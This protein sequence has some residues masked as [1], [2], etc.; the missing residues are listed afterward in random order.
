MQPLARE[1]E[2]VDVL[3]PLQPV[4]AH[5][6]QAMQWLAAHGQG[7]S[8]AELIASAAADLEQLEGRLAALSTSPQ[9]G[10]LG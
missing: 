5:G 9:T 6:N 8:V 3:A 10:T 4:L 2:L 1:L 7:A